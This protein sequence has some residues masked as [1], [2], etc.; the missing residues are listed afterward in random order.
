[1]GIVKHNG[2]SNLIFSSSTFQEPFLFSVFVLSCV[3]V[4]FL[5]GWFFLSLHTFHSYLPP[6]LYV[7]ITV[8]SQ[9]QVTSQPLNL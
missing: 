3:I 1:M 8:A 6:Q 2:S 5:I 9:F 4:L 7:L